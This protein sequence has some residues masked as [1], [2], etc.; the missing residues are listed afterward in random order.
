MFFFLHGRRASIFHAIKLLS[1]LNARGFITIDPTFHISILCPYN[2][3]SSLFLRDIIQL[4]L[5]VYC[6]F[7]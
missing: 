5:A 6:Y 1:F 4:I 7:R 2:L 3:H